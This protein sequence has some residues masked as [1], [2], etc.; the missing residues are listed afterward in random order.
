MESQ[1]MVERPLVVFHQKNS[2][3]GNILAVRLEELLWAMTNMGCSFGLGLWRLHTMAVQVERPWEF[4]AEG[5]DFRLGLCRLHTIVVQ[6]ERPW[7]FMAERFGLWDWPLEASHYAWPKALLPIF[8]W[9]CIFNP[10]L[11]T[12]NKVGPLNPTASRLGWP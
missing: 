8:Y 2:I 11:W 7:E 6:V 10:F 12:L 9:L 1:T 3:I 5:L 4:T